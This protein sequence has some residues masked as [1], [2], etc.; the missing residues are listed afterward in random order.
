MNPKT[1]LFIPSNDN[2]VKIFHPIYE[3]LKSKFHIVFLSQESYKNEGVEKTLLDLGIDFKKFEEY[4][5]KDPDYILKK[6]NVGIVVI[7]NDVDVIPQWFIHSANNLGLSS[8]LIQDGLLFDINTSKNIKNKLY[9][10]SKISRL[11]LLALRLIFSRQYKRITDGEGGCTQIQV[12]GKLSESYMLN[13]GIDRDK[14]VITGSP[15]WNE[16]KQIKHTSHTQKIV[17]YAPTELIHT[18]ILKQME[19]MELAD[20]VCSV[21]LSHKNTKL[22]IKPHPRE[23]PKFYE[24]LKKKYSSEL[25]ISYGH[26][27]SLLEESDVLV[28]NLST[29]TIESLAARKPV[30]IFFPKIETIVNSNTFPR[31]LIEKNIVLYANDKSL[32]H[33]HLLK[34]LNGE[35]SHNESLNFVLEQYLGPQDSVASR[36]AD[37]IAKL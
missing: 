7:G 14:I 4:E 22:I 9:L 16:I 32:L 27:Y 15:L 6:E 8:V 5:K 17:L 36:S 11:K 10:I 2:H 24:P 29:V 19:L 23:N 30:I 33:A 3:I 35:Y 20:A 25:E 1:V 34:T 37:F 13:K 21:V 26:F 28:T 31:D 18:N 12:W